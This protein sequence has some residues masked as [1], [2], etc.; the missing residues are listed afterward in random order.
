[1]ARPGVPGSSIPGVWAAAVP[2]RTVADAQAGALRFTAAILFAALILQRFG[3]PLGGKAFSLV[4]PIGLGLAAWGVLGGTLAFDRGRLA[5]YCALAAC[6]VLGLAW[7]ALSPAG[8]GG[9][10][11]N[12][13]SLAQFL[14]LTSFACLTF[15]EPVDERRFFREVNRW[16]AIIAA[17]GVLQFV[18]QFVGVRIFSFTGIVPGVLLFEFGYNLVIPTGIGDTLKSNGFFLIEPSVFSQVMALAL[19]IEVVAFR[20]VA[21]LCLCVAGLLTSFAGTGWIVLGSFVAAAG[22]GLGWR[23]LAIATGL[24]LVVAVLFGVVST[25][26]PDVYG[27]F[28]QRLDEISRPGTS[29]HRRFITP[30]WLLDDTLT[31]TPSAA[32]LGLGSGVSERLTM[33]YAYDVNTPIKI[34]LDYGFPALLAYVLLFVLGR[35]SPVQGAILVPAAVMFFITGSYTQ[36]PPMLFLVLLLTSVARLRTDQAAPASR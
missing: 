13:Q 28:A 24:V 8:F 6:A 22:L 11:A 12:L 1:M 17:A 19:I 35:K 26:A 30:F 7:H 20:R 27:A 34:E 10:G 16:F 23:G 18:L 31:S 2:G 15:A 14:L 33:P 5:A 32:L 21:F 36:F 25:F 3:L 29:G 9:S 4:G